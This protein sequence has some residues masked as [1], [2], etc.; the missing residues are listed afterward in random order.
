MHG[1]SNTCRK[2]QLFRHYRHDG[3]YGGQN[4]S[5][6]DLP[7]NATVVATCW[8]YLHRF[9]HERCIACTNNLDCQ[10]LISSVHNLGWRRFFCVGWY[11]HRKCGS[12]WQ[13]PVFICD[14]I[15]TNLG[16]YSSHHDNHGCSCTRW[17]KSIGVNDNNQC[18][19]ERRDCKFDTVYNFD[20]IN[21]YNNDD[22]H[23]S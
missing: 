14:L 16:V 21:D 15:A 9:C 19:S 2:C 11:L 23:Y 6:V 20:H 10:L 12:S 7:I 5:G 1:G 17:T 4:C 18:C 8:W 22:D 13:R 3:D